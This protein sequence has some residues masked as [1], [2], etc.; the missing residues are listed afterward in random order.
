MMVGIFITKSP[1]DVH[2]AKLSLPTLTRTYHSITGN[3]EEMNTQF[4]TILYRRN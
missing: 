4:I 2:L 1:S 3:P